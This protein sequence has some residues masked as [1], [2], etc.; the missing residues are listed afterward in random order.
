MTAGGLTNLERVEQIV[1]FLI[2]FKLR[3]FF[4]I[5]FINIL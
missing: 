3:Y 4:V 5:V 1:L 2:E